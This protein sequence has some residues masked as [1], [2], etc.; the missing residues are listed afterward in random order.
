ME[1]ITLDYY[2]WRNTE[3]LTLLLR[4][5]GSA[6]LTLADFFI[7]GQPVTPNPTVRCPGSNSPELNVNAPACTVMLPTVLGNCNAV[8]DNCGVAY[9]VRVVTSDGAIFDFSCIAGETS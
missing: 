8:V 7:A 4:N 2:Q 6:Q 9:N 5:T 1:K 3:Y